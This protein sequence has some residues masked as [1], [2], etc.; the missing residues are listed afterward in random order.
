MSI[1]RVLSTRD[2]DYKLSTGVSQSG[3][4]VGVS[5]NNHGVSL[6]AISGKKKQIDTP[7]QKPPGDIYLGERGFSGLLASTDNDFI[8]RFS[9]DDSWMYHFE[10]PWG[11]EPTS[12]LDSVCAVSNP[13]EGTG[14]VLYLEEGEE[15]W[16]ENLDDSVG[17]EVSANLEEGKIAVGAGHYSLNSDPLSRFGT[18]GVIFYHWGEQQWFQETEEDVI[19]ISLNDDEDCVVAG[20][21]DGSLIS[22]DLEGKRLFRKDGVL[23]AS[24]V[25]WESEED[26][27]FISISGDKNSIVSQV[28]DEV[29]CFDLRGDV[30]WETQVDG[31]ALDERQIRVDD[32]GDRALVATMEGT[33]YVIDEGNVIW[34][35]QYDAKAVR[36][37]ISKDGRVWCVSAL[38]GTQNNPNSIEV[39][40]ER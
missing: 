26:G 4:V 27:G 5:T 15:T 24:N 35:K 14:S 29:R 30:L 39:F 33:V 25:R 36:G 2:P 20:L 18:A 3:E 38:L 9:Q 13:P 22:Y 34:K 37:S 11:V 31:F 40:Q 32:A 19:G 7:N 1:E 10:Y 12:D 28:G 17:L 16:K 21:D 8:M 23:T 6:F